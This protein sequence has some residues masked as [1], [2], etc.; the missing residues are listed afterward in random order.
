MTRTAI[1]EKGFTLIE[2][3]IAS[4]ILGL[5]FVAVVSVMSQSL[6]NISRVQV[7]EQVL[8]H[9]REQ[10]TE[11]LVQRPLVPGH[12]SGRWSDGYRWQAD[13]IPEENPA[14]T[15]LSSNSSAYALYRIHLQISWGNEEHPSSYVLETTQLARKSVAAAGL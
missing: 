13:V 14:L 12:F 9:A 8:L 1:A 5:A 11:L 10:M 4:A 6:R 2:V 7:H 15:S 3:L